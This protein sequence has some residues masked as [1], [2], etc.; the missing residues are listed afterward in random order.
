MHARLRECRAFPQAKETPEEL[1]LHD[2]YLLKWYWFFTTIVGIGLPWAVPRLWGL[3]PSTVEALESYHSLGIYVMF[4]VGFIWFVLSLRKGHLRYQFS[5]FGL[6]MGVLIV[7]VSQSL[8]Q[9]AN[10]YSGLIWFFLPSSLVIVNDIFAYLFG[11]AF[12]RT[13]L[14][15]LSPKKTVEGYVGAAAMT[16][17]WAWVVGRQ[18]ESLQLFVCPQPYIS[19]KPFA[20][21]F[22]LQCTPS[23]VYLPTCTDLT[24][25]RFG[26]LWR[27]TQ[28]ADAGSSA[29]SPAAAVVEDPRNQALR[30]R[31]QQLLQRHAELLDAKV[32]TEEELRALQR[33]RHS[34]RQAASAGQDPSAE[35]PS[36]ALS[37]SAVSVSVSVSSAPC[38]AAGGVAGGDFF[39]REAALEEQ[40]AQIGAALS[41][42]DRARAAAEA[43]MRS[44]CRS[45][46]A[47]PF[48]L[49]AM[50][51]GSFAAFFAP[52]GGFF[53]SGFKRA[54]RI[55]ARRASDGLTPLLPRDF[56]ES[57]CS[58]LVGRDA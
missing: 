40:K 33:M 37:A 58:L 25:D 11:T 15:K 47:A 23:P 9:V 32:Q 57:E 34:W 39:A 1:R 27:Q 51:L 20:M 3:A 18:L 29:L 10:I 4:L 52:F 26:K 36:G 35:A 14:I 7:V 17:L 55:K 5:Q 45:L 42:V 53:A 44:Q 46:W 30:E 8:I 31:R 12:G 6:A 38:E 41:L 24:L 48:D 22:E 16:L 28:D 2:F 56:A 19:F 50:V 54:V 21:F 43:E 49:H 13:R